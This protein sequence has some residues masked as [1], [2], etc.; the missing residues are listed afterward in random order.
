MQ[1]N[2]SKKAMVFI[3]GLIIVTTISCNLIPAGI[4]NGVDDT[5]QPTVEIIPTLTATLITDS[6]TDAQGMAILRMK[7]NKTEVNIQVLDQKDNQPLGNMFVTYVNNGI[8]TLVIVQDPAGKY[9]PTAKELPTSNSAI[10]SKKGL[11]KYVAANNQVSLAV[12]IVLISAMEAFQNGEEWGRF[13]ADIPEIQ[14][15]SKE[16]KE[17]CLNPEQTKEGIGA[18]VGTGGILLSA[19][20]DAFGILAGDVLID[21]LNLVAG[22]LLEESIT[23]QLD[24]KIDKQTPQIVKWKIYKINDFIPYFIRP[25]GYC[26]APQ[27]KN[28]LQ[29]A[30]DWV[31]YG[32][33]H[34]DIYVMNIMSA[35]T[36][37]YVFYIE[38]GDANPKDEFLGD[39]Q[40]RSASQPACVGIM[41]HQDGMYSIW[42]EGWDPLWEIHEACYASCWDID[43]PYTSNL[44]GIFLG[45]KKDERYQIHFA[46][47]NVYDIFPEVYG[48]E[49]QP[50]DTKMGDL[51]TGSTNITS[52][53][54]A[55]AQRMSV[56]KKGSVCTKNDGVYL[57]NNP[58]KSGTKLKLLEPGTQF[59]VVGGP[60]CASDW[61]FWEIRLSNGTTGWISEGGD[62]LD[63][64]FICPVN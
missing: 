19:V 42:Y 4:G 46:W 54:N 15:W 20:G 37:N 49:M 41:D 60:K 3:A 31:K 47:M 34:D 48:Y 14:N 61:S 44:V 1:A 33:E 59:T 63:P 39:L 16:T 57:R 43:P 40:K 6:Y 5:P 62:A 25:E 11:A 10:E 24:Q 38:G 9:L 36:I 26:L 12:V 27:D 2:L 8:K 22:N 21:G 30:I 29:S 52:C 56:G 17:I 45:N 58:S 28:S 13:L 32:I 50:C 7:D 53:P 18:V 35:D 55:P 51:T 23:D 64:Y